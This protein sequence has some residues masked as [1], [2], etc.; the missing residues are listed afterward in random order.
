MS[1]YKSA[2]I[3]ILLILLLFS[4]INAST[5][6]AA[7]Q[8]TVP[9]HFQPVDINQNNKID[10]DEATDELAQKFFDASDKDR[11]IILKLMDSRAKEKFI[12]NLIN[13]YICAR[14]TELKRICKAMIF[15]SLKNDFD[16]LNLDISKLSAI[17]NI[18]NKNKESFTKEDFSNLRYYYLAK[19]NYDIVK[20]I[21]NDNKISTDRKS[22]IPVLEDKNLTLQKL[23]TTIFEAA[24]ALIMHMPNDET[25]KTKGLVFNILKFMNETIGKT[26]LGERDASQWPAQKILASGA[27]NGCVENAKLFREL[28][29]RIDP[30]TPCRY[31]GS[32]KKAWALRYPNITEQPK[33]PE[34]ARIK[35]KEEQ[36]LEVKKWV[37]DMKN[38]TTETKKMEEW[39]NSEGHA[40]VE[41]KDLTDSS[42]FLVD[43]SAFR[44]AFEIKEEDTTRTDKARRGKVIQFPSE[45]LD[46]RIEKK[47]NKFYVTYYKFGHVDNEKHRI[48]TY[49]FSTIKEV[50]ELLDKPLMEKRKSSIIIYEKNGGFKTGNEYIIFEKKKERGYPDP[51]DSNLFEYTITIR[52]ALEWLENPAGF[53]PDMD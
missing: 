5:S 36:K 7:E 2:V 25:D 9:A 27:S 49:K 16:N 15:M 44:G 8:N 47:D 32:F 17:D 40:I 20:K 46:V 34:I 31:V 21:Y 26:G 42:T 38:W 48:A 37:Q 19:K 39:L 12:L 1:K 43:T 28:F 4:G 24:V 22:E 33:T 50:N 53:A 35:T 51:V 10:E 14:D 30:T 52:K 3:L 13:S 18:L 41:I 11:E 23:E 45:G 29:M 6:I